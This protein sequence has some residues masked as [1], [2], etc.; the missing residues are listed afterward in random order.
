MSV[1]TNHRSGS[2]TR[3]FHESARTYRYSVCNARIFYYAVG[4]NAAISADLCGSE[5]LHKGLDDGV[6][7]HFDVAV[8]NAGVGIEN[9]DALIQKSAAR[10]QPHLGIEHHH[11]CTG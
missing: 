7:A 10:G 3:V 2:H 8:S 4:A 6:G 1:R 9:G 11:F 5:Q